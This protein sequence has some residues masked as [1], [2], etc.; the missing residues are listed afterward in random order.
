MD[1][2]TSMGNE[3]EGKG[4]MLAVWPE[5]T[6]PGTLT[7]EKYK[8][9]FAGISARSGAHQLIGSNIPQATWQYVGSYLMSPEQEKLQDYRKVKLVPFGEYIPLEDFVKSLFPD[10]AILGELGSF[11]PGNR[12]QN[13]LNLAG[14]PLGST[15]CY[16]SIFPQLRLAQNRQGAK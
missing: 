7:E 6:V 14:V 13:L 10:V 15:I 12:G 16:E 9:L 8:Q 1:T 2:I 4:V 11:T 3:L 5:S